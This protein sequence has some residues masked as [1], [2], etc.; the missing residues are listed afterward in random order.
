MADK[1]IR[2]LRRLEGRIVYEI[3]GKDLTEYENEDSRR[4]LVY[5]DDGYDVFF[6][7]TGFLTGIKGAELIGREGVTDMTNTFCLNGIE[8]GLV[9]YSEN[10]GMIALRY[11]RDLLPDQLDFCRRLA[12]EISIRFQKLSRTRD[13]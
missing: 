3:D 12:Y 9:Y 7:M 1:E 5:F 2:V 4:V 11:A 10:F 13:L 8:F 6:E